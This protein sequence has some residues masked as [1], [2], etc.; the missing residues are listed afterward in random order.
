MVKIFDENYLRANDIINQARYKLQKLFDNSST[1]G[2]E[3]QEAYK[4]IETLLEH[5]EDAEKSLEYL[6]KPTKE[7]RL[8]KDLGGKFFIAYDDGTE[9]YNLSCGSTVEVYL[10]EDLE[11]DVEEG[12]HIGRVEHK[13]KNGQEGYYFY[14]ANKPFLYEGMRSR[15]RVD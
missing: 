1:K 12:W 14:G 3:N 10:Q 5:L 2:L 11:E 15:K 13:S 8:A 6:S 9:S 7:G 4:E